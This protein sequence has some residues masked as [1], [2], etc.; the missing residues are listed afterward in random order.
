M[1]DGD[2][3]LRAPPPVPRAA[4]RGPNYSAR[5]PAARLSASAASRDSSA[6]G[7][8]PTLPRTAAVPA[9]ASGGQMG[10]VVML[11][12]EAGFPAP[13]QPR[14]LTSYRN[15]PVA[16]VT[17]TTPGAGDVGPGCSS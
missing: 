9:H 7:G 1:L 3:E 14:K 10:L 13:A 2:E 15:K 6:F 5:P 11:L 8:R 16:V 12:H 4:L 17:S